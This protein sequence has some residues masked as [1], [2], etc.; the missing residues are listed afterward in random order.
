MKV[1]QF[2]AQSSDDIPGML[3]DLAD[4]IERGEF[5]IVHGLSWVADCG[6]GRIEIDYCGKSPQPGINAHFLFA[7]GMR[8]LE[9]L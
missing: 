7:L 8:R 9:L 4:Q 5:G 1:L 2:P 6:D 3:R